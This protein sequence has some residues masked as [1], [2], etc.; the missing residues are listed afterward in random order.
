VF[1]EKTYKATI[2]GVL[3][4]LILHNGLLA[5]PSYEYTQLVSSLKEK[6]KSGGAEVVRQMDRAK[7]FGGLYLSNG[8][9]ILPQAM[10]QASLYNGASIVDVKKGKRWVNGITV[11]GHAEIKYNGPDDL[12]QLFEAGQHTLKLPVVVGGSRIVGVRPLFPEWSAEFI[13][14]V[15]TDILDAGTAERIIRTTGRQI[16]LGDWRP[17][18]KGKYGRFLLEEIEEIGSVSYDSDTSSS[19]EDE[20]EAA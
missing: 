20:L 17:Q 15:E 5:D 2:K 8:R 3:P 10:L 13:F 12:E 9:P 6:V 1:E 18:K 7:W 19:D 16:G 4:G 11:Q 14:T